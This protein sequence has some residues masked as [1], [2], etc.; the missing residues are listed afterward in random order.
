M[1]AGQVQRLSELWSEVH[2][3]YLSGVRDTFQSRALRWIKRLPNTR[4]DWSALLQA[5]EGHDSSVSAVAFSPDGKTLASGSYDHTV[6]L[7]DPATGQS[8]QTLEGHDDWV[9][10]VTFSP[11]GRTLASGSGDSTIC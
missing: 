1:P 11:D 3:A 4:Q 8:L 5:L 6:R 7:W 9:S 10:A 2:L